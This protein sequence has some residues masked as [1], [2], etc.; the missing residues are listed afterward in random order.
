V[1]ATT[2]KFLK[3]NKY[4]VDTGADSRELR[5][6]LS[7]VR[8]EVSALRTET[9]HGINAIKQS[10]RDATPPRNNIDTAL[11]LKK[12]S[13]LHGALQELQPRFLTPISEGVKRALAKITIV[14]KK[15]A[16]GSGDVKWKRQKAW[17]AERLD[18]LDDAVGNTGKWEVDALQREL[19]RAMRELAERLERGDRERSE[20][21]AAQQAA[22]ARKL[23]GIIRR[24]SLSV[25]NNDSDTPTTYH[26][27][28]LPVDALAD[29]MTDVLEASPKLT[30]ILEG[31][32]LSGGGSE[33]ARFASMIQQLNGELPIPSNEPAFPLNERKRFTAI[34]GFALK[35]ST[36]DDSPSISLQVRIARWSLICIVGVKLQTPRLATWRSS[37]T[38]FSRKCAG[39]TGPLFKR[40]RKRRRPRRRTCCHISS[41]T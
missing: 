10:I 27:Y 6:S 33:A 15:K 14:N 22:M 28:E 3:F 5:R 40:C 20:K 2:G 23:D 25:S 16:K 24:G 37:R 4:C 9:Q 34:T 35:A 1:K 39:G 30:R 12:M 32:M 38:P 31:V 29:K 7:E 8:E 19:T 13:E 18:S 26:Q 11:L 36:L 41:T 21:A 17:L